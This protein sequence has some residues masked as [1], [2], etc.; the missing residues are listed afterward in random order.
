MKSSL[1]VFKKGC[2][3]A[4]KNGVSTSEQLNGIAMYIS[5]LSMDLTVLGSRLV[6]EQD[7]YVKNVYARQLA[8]L[9]YEFIQDYPNL[10][11]K[12]FRKIIGSGTVLES[13]NL[14]N[15]KIWE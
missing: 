12:Q 13:V 1:L 5:I 15:R 14:G 6:L 3:R 8:I 2:Q 10:F 9:I 7:E 11:S 4:K